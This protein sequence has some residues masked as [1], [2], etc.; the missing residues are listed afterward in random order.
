MSSNIA[1]S[2]SFSITHLLLFPS[3]S[4]SLFLNFF[5]FFTHSFSSMWAS[6][7]DEN[8]KHSHWPSPSLSPMKKKSHTHTYLNDKV[9]WNGLLT[10]T[11]HK[12]NGQPNVKHQLTLYA[13]HSPEKHTWK[14]FDIRRK[15][16]KKKKKKKKLKHLQNTHTIH[17]CKTNTNTHQETSH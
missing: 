7:N 17:T 10:T 11:N 9:I 8:A 16:K 3:L 1:L 5:S 12:T 15:V 6:L 2:L 14:T 4:L 13:F